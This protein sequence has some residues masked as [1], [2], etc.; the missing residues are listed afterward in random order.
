MVQAARTAKVTQVAD[1][2]AKMKANRDIFP[3]IPS[4]PNL[5]RQK[6]T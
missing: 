2:R 4:T 3:F 5:R 6:T 1:A